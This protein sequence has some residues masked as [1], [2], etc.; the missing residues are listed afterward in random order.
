MPKRE[1]ISTSKPF[2]HEISDTFRNNFNKSTNQP[3]DLQQLE[4]IQSSQ[5]TITI[6]IQDAGVTISN[7]SL[8]KSS[9]ND[10][11]QKLMSSMIGVSQNSPYRREDTQTPQVFNT[12][13]TFAGKNIHKSIDQNNFTDQFKYEL[14]P[15][16]Y[17]PT[18]APSEFKVNQ[19]SVGTNRDHTVTEEQ[20]FNNLAKME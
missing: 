1:S 11:K 10:F 4:S 17:N 19:V 6:P 3:L 16:F 12:K 8:I 20:S 18:S 14:H 13:N 15:D 5:R 2:D 7:K 9:M